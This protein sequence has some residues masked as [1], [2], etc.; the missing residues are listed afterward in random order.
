MRYHSRNSF[1]VRSVLQCYVEPRS[2][3]LHYAKKQNVKE[4]QVVPRIFEFVLSNKR[5][6]FFWVFRH[7]LKT[8][9]F[10][11]KK[12]ADVKTYL[13]TGGRKFTLLTTCLLL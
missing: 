3:I 6:H 1:V 12:M 11:G 8:P 13:Y 7:E 4:L 2:T 10:S 9:I 5:N